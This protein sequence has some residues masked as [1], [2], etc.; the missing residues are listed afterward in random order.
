MST[1]SKKHFWE[2]FRRHHSEFKGL[3]T[4]SGRE[5]AYWVNEVQAHLN[6]Y[7]KFLSF[8]LDNLTEDT[9]VLTITVNGKAKYFKKVEEFVAKAPEIDGWTIYALERPRPIDF[10]L[11]QLVQECGIGPRE[12]YF[13]FAGDGHYS[14]DIIIYHPLCTSE[15]NDLILDIADCAVYNLLG[16]RSYGNDIKRFEAANLST[17]DPAAIEKLEALPHFIGM[18]KSSIVVDQQGNLVS[19]I[20]G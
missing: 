8:C 18:R 16:E 4:K 5:F 2:W 6:A 7:F 12:L 3:E 9:S 10:S 14:G 20:G 1:L 13:S 17:A 11:E 19:S 15:N